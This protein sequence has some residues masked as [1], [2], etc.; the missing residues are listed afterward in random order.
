M[1]IRPTATLAAATASLLVLSGVTYAAVQSVDPNPDAQVVIP[2]LHT[3]SPHPSRSTQQ[4]RRHGKD[5]PAAHDSADDHSAG[6]GGRGD[7]ST[8]PGD[9]DGD[10]GGGGDKGEPGGGKPSPGGG[11]KGGEPSPT[12]TPGGGG[13]KGGGGGKGGKPTPHPSPSGSD[14]HGGGGG[15]K[16]GKPDPSPSSTGGDDDGGGGH[17]GK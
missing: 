12:P 3:A 16:G 11:H 15:H 13:D 6:S 7:Q 10:K 17:G 9:G 4:T 14:D 8:E 5:D 1:R 2:S